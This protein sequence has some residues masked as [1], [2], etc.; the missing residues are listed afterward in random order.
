MPVHDWQRVSAGTFHDF[1]SAWITHLKESLNGGVLPDGYFALAEQHAGDIVPDVLTLQLRDAP[2]T[3]FGDD[4]GAI[5]VAVRPPKV[6]R[7][8]VMS[9]SVEYRRRR[10]TLAIRHSR[11]HRLVALI[12]IVSPA[13]KDR[14][15]SVRGFVDKVASALSNECHVLVVDL[16]PPGLH[17]ANR[18]HGAISYEVGCQDEEELPADQPLTLSSFVAE[19]SVTGY[20]ETLAVGDPLPEMPLFLTPDDYI[21]VPLAETYEQAYR[22]MPAV[23]RDVLEGRRDAE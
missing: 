18:L 22:G 1:H 3:P 10:R 2:R 16:F 19:G 20:V 15:R 12:E 13:N 5:A 11:G 6:S 17:D 21:N 14:P 8:V 9:E 23:L 4:S 7:K